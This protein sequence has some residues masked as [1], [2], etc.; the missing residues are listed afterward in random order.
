M[1]R[2]VLG[3]LI[4]AAATLPSSARQADLTPADGIRI[5]RSVNT[6]QA[7]LS[8]RGGG[9]ASLRDV[10]TDGSFSAAA[11]VQLSGADS[12]TIRSHRLSLTRTADARGYQLSLTPISGCGAAWF[13]SESG[14]IFTGRCLE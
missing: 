12:A 13:S 11:D 2:L 7:Q 9:Y 10:V 14:L 5:V 6:T 1:R 8:R 4:G 3:L